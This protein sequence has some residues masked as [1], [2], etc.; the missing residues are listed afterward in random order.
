M[1]R[2]YGFSEAQVASGDYNPRMFNS[3]LDGTKSAIEMCA[4][5]NAAG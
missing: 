3:F 2:Y 1:W 5:A 4:V